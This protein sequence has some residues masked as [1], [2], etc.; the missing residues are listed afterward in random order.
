VVFK[1]LTW[2][3]NFKGIGRLKVFGAVVISRKNF[4]GWGL[5]G[6]PVTLELLKA[7]LEDKP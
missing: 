7:V 1:R 4:Q 3:P 6:N 2:H 5:A